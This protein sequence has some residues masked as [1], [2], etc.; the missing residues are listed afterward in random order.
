LKAHVDNGVLYVSGL[1]VGKVWNVFNVFGTTVYQN[2]ASGEKAELILP[3]R[4]LYLVTDGTEVIKIM[5]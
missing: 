4:G 1:T 2:V 3:G 5:N